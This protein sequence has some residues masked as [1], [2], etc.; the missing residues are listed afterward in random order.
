MSRFHHRESQQIH[1]RPTK[2]S[3]DK[4]NPPLDNKAIDVLTP[5]EDTIEDAMMHTRNP[6]M[7][8]SNALDV[9]KSIFP[10]NK[11]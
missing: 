6:P 2:A 8:T 3:Y 9:D 5:K 1:T 4:I 10:A 11:I 7:N